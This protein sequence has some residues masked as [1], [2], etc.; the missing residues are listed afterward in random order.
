MYPQVDDHHRWALPDVLAFQAVARPETVFVSMVDGPSLTYSDVFADAQKVAG[1][2]YSLGV[3]PGDRVAVLLH[4]SIDFVR[5]WTGLG[6]L[7]AVL[8]PLNTALVGDFLAHQIHS[9]AAKVVVCHERYLPKLD[10]IRPALTSVSTTVICGAAP[11]DHKRPS[12]L[13]SFE[14]WRDASLHRG[15]RPGY[16]DLACIMYTSGTTGPSKGVLMPHAHC[17]LFAMPIIDFG[18][19]CAADKYYVST[20]FFHVNGLFMSLY[21]TL[22][23]G[24][25]A[26]V[27]ERFSASSWVRDIRDHGCTVT[28]LVGAMSQMVIAQ[29]V[30]E[31][32]S[33]HKLRLVSPLPNSADHDSAFRHRFGVPDVLT[34]YG[35]TE[36]NLPLWGRLEDQRP[37]T[38][39]FS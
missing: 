20:P 13:V 11:V 14:S 2:F 18:H 7:G 1:F 33:D 12:G 22:I 32:D 5:V 37:G 19:L 15:N 28:N 39:G 36:V 24:A 31:L 23:V 3:E 29:P 35:M 6:W 21:A 10:A 34:G 25:T 38:V 26:V 17:Y 9:S 8:V 4:N 30:S 27:R 16:R